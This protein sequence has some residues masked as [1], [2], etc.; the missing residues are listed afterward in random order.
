MPFMYSRGNLKLLIS[1]SSKMSKYCHFMLG[2]LCL[3]DK[4]KLLCFLM[5]RNL[6]I[7]IPIADK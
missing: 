5:G 1:L 3:V 4:F 2:L 6:C 7:V